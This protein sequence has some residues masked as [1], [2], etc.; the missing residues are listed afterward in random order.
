MTY[1]VWKDSFNIGVKKMDEQFA[2][3]EVNT[4]INQLP[5]D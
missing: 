4:K 3:E 5:N 1:F 2:V